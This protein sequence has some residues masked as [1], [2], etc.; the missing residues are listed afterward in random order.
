MDPMVENPLA[1]G[2]GQSWTRLIESIGPARMLLVIESRMSQRLKGTLSAE[3][4]WQEVLIQAWRDR[5]AF[6]WRGLRSFT[7]WLLTLIDHRIRD[8][9]VHT[10]ALKRGGGAGAVPLAA[11]GTDSLLTLLPPELIA[12][13]TPSRMAV[14]REQA[15]AMQ[16]ALADLPEEQREVVRLRLFEEL[17]LE[18]IAERLGITFAAVR[19]RFARGAE[20]YRRRLRP[21]E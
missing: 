10:D 18:Q 11:A 15:A 21:H 2:S 12:T 20:I 14:Y 5:E 9:A 17:T 8:A 13:T 4:I 3:D 6:E 16:A 19:H 1:S 7:A